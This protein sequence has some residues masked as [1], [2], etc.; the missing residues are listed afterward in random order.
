MEEEEQELLIPD[1]KEGI[2]YILA[3]DNAA[4]GQNLNEFVIDGEKDLPSSVMN[5]TAREVHFGATKFAITEGGTNGRLSTD[6]QGALFDSIMDF[7][8]VNGSHI[9]PAEAIIYKGQTS[10]KATFYLA[11]AEVGQYDVISELPD[12]TQ[13][14]LPSYFTVV[15]STNVNLGVKL[16]A[17]KATRINGFAP[18]SV[19]YVNSGQNDITISELLLTVQ[20]GQLSPTIEGFATNPQT[21]IHIKPN[22]E[23]DKFGYVT[24]PPGKQETV[25]FYFKQT[26]GYTYLKL[27]IVK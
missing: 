13:A 1:V 18:V 11:N 8:L 27:Y 14:T 21:E 19:T 7:R 10:S 9:I 5:I 16:D 15:P 26:S 6:V 12:G 22:L 4:V 24:I 23:S 25:N 3:Q 2:Y 17:P 20:G